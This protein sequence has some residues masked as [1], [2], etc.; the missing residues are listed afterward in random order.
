MFEPMNKYLSVEPIKEEKKSSGILVPDSYESDVSAFSVV[1][2]LK[3]NAQSNLKPGTKIVVP[4]H[5]I[6]EITLFGKTYH[7]VLENN[8]IGFFPN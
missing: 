1:S 6:E 2:L 3:A 8:V 5:M 7:V 4:T